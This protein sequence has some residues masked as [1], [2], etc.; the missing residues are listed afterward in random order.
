MTSF[1]TTSTFA[2]SAFIHTFVLDTRSNLYYRLLLSI[3]KSQRYKHLV[4]SVLLRTAAPVPPSIT[5]KYAAIILSLAIGAFALPQDASSTTSAPAT[6]A[7]A[8]LT[9]QQS[10]ALACDAGDVTC[11]AACLGIAHP[12]SSQAV[13]T[14]ECAEKCDQ[15]DGSPGAT[16]KY[17]QCVQACIAS[18]FPSSQTVAVG[19]AAS[20]GAATT[21]SAASAASSG[22]CRYPDIRF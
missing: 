2:P 15:G 6:T 1:P 5:M 3:Q 22:M 7:A 18:Y 20:S 17:S 11:Q 19:A 10:C 4:Y 21:G 14:T 9:S 13:E 8:A 12:N 16:E